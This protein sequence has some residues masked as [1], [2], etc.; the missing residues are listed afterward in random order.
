MCPELKIVPED[1]PWAAAGIVW[2]VNY[3][4]GTGSAALQLPLFQIDFA[5]NSC[6]GN[7]KSRSKSRSV[8]LLKPW[9][10]VWGHFW[11]GAV[12]VAVAVHWQDPVERPGHLATPL[13]KKS[14]PPILPGLVLSTCIRQAAHSPVRTPQLLSNVSVIRERDRLDLP[15][16][17]LSDHDALMPNWSGPL[18]THFDRVTTARASTIFSERPPS[19][20]HTL[21]FPVYSTLRYPGRAKGG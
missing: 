1:A 17:L 21:A 19:L 13:V 12:V 15:P 4:C 8:E 16:K 2:Y 11:A 5:S 20:Q 6:L 18:S 3:D 14:H 10:R 9:H 7:F